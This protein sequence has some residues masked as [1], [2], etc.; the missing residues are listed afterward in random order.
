[1]LGNGPTS[2]RVR[3]TVVERLIGVYDADG[4]VWGELSYWVGAR[5]G[6]VHCAL[7][8]ITHSSVRER[9]EWRACRAGLPVPFDTY[10]RDDQPDSIRTV[11]DGALP[12]VVAETDGGPV[13]VVSRRELEA[14]DGSVEAL[15][16]LLER[17]VAADEIA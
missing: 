6:R 4:T 2:A 10:H 13:V 7:C 1:V 3:T 15:N 16:G 14:C 12:C 17:V 5:L 9:S 8:D 11:T